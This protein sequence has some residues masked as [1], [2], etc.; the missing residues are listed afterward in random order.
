MQVSGH[1]ALNM[2]ADRNLP[3]YNGTPKRALYPCKVSCKPG[4]GHPEKLKL[5]S[6][7]PKSWRN[8]LLRN[9][10]AL[11]V[12]VQSVTCAWKH[13]YCQEDMRHRVDT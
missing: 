5:Q 3:N 11:Q 1:F 8:R 9:Y 2:G 13:G 4:W 7:S 12:L 10:H 6:L